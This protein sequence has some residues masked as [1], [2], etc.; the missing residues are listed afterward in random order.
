MSDSLNISSGITQSFNSST[1][2]LTITSSGSRTATPVGFY[3]AS[4]GANYEL[5]YV[6]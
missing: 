5:V 2:V 1:H 6:Y 3:G 4:S